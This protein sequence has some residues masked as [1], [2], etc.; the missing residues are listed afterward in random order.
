MGAQGWVRETGNRLVSSKAHQVLAAT[1]TQPVT[2]NYTRLSRDEHGETNTIVDF[3][4]RVV[5]GLPVGWDATYVRL[6][7][8]VCLCV[9]GACEGV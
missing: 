2:L 7:G 5:S 8:F 4:L 1:P 3:V 9:F 6:C